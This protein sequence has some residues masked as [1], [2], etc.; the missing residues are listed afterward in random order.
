MSAR[1]LMQ[2]CRAPGTPDYTMG[3]VHYESGQELNLLS[4]LFPN[5]RDELAGKV[6][7]DFGCGF[8]YQSIACALAGAREVIGVDTNENNLRLASDNVAALP[9]LKG[10]LRFST[11]VPDGVKA[12]IIFSQNSFEHFLEPEQILA[13]MCAALMPRGKIFIGF[14]PPWYAPW[15][16]HMTFFCRLPWV[17]LLFSERTVMEGRSLYRSDG[18]RSYREA[19]LA[20]MSLGRFEKITKASGLVCLDVR[21]DCSK[22]L[23]FLRWTPLREFF[24]C[25]VRCVLMRPEDS[26]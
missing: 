16:A 26:V 12:D 18:R 9:N 19:G 24:V 2:F 5:F 6:V 21:Y 3:G 15:G 17:H 7:I 22:G 1:L 14:G 23:D 25:Y 20:Q 10:K 13:S 11:R 4:E 8:G